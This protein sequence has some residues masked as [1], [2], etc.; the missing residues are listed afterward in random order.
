M[1]STLSS[2]ATASLGNRD[3]TNP[4]F[5]AR[6]ATACILGDSLSL[7]SYGD[8]HWHGEAIPTTETTVEGVG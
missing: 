3:R 7:Q 6:Y 2:P 4:G 1:S 8:G 5:I